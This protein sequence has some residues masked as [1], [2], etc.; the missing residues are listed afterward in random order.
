MGL[1]QFVSGHAS[2]QDASIDEQFCVNLTSQYQTGLT[3]LC[4]A[5]HDAVDDGWTYLASANDNDI[6]FIK[7]GRGLFTV[8][9]RIEYREPL[10]ARV[11]SSQ[12]LLQFECTNYRARVVQGTVFEQHGLLGAPLEH[13]A[14]AEPWLTAPP[15][16]ILE[17]LLNVACE[18]ARS[19][20][21]STG[22]D[23]LLRGE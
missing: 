1:L 3:E 13:N 6:W 2:A 9:A 18:H 22:L 19:S 5:M 14:E 17:V 16:S 21:S 7:P 11:R 8:W 4:R 23:Q 12:Q 10:D 20:S 15:G